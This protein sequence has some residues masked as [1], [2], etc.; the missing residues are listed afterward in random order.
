MNHLIHW[1]APSP[2]WPEVSLSA[3]PASRRVLRRPA[4]LRFSS[5]SFMEQFTATLATEPASLAARRAT[6][7]K[8]WKRQAPVPP[9]AVAPPL[10]PRA[11][12]TK[13]MK[14]RRAARD[15]RPPNAPPPPPPADP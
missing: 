13:L 8:W 7:E 9:P 15:A 1:A 12:A 2:F 14:L 5:D 10:P 6:P 11:L 4:L 3:D